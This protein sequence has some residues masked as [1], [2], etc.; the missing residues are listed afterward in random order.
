M[1]L[2]LGLALLSLVA[3]VGCGG[4]DEWSAKRPKV[5]KTTGVVTMDGKPVDDAQV[6]DSTC[7]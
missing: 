7:Y 1:K 6:V 5:Y 3:V 2:P 4:D